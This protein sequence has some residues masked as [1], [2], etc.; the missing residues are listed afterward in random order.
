M[1]I[2]TPFSNRHF[3]WNVM[4]VLKLILAEHVAAQLGDHGHVRAQPGRHDG[5]VG[6][7]AAE[8]QLK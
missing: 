3:T 5:L 7:F 6:A 8:P 2:S 4:G 1:I